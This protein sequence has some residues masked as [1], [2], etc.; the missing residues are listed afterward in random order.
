MGLLF[1][2]YV[3]KRRLLNGKEVSQRM[4]WGNA[5]LHEQ[6]FSHAALKVVL[7]SAESG[8]SLSRGRLHVLG[9]IAVGTKTR[10][11]LVIPS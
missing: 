1:D 6:E 2:A 4:S 8:D 11:V 10:I 9:S 7:C 3:D 5:T